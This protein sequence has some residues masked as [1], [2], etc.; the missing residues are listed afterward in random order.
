MEQANMKK[1]FFALVLVV[2]CT[3]AER[4]NWASLG[5]AG[6]IVCYSGGNIIYDGYSTGK[7]ATVTNSDGWQFE[8][9]KTGR[10]VRVS[11]ACVIEN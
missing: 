5:S 11:G 1:W 2:G 7:I 3:D 4:A 9:K 10:F 8:D 6:H